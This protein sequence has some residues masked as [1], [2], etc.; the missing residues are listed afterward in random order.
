MNVTR[1]RLGLVGLAI[2]VAC[3]A[4]DSG[5]SPSAP[6]AAP[7]TSAIAAT[8]LSS[9]ASAYPTAAG[10]DLGAGLG[11]DAARPAMTDVRGV[12]GRIDAASMGFAL[13]L[14]SGAARVRAADRTEIIILGTRAPVPF[15]ALTKGMRVGV[16]GVKESGILHA[17]RIV[18]LPD[19]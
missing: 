9:G 3:G 16:R 4:C 17:R 2:V 18:I 14:P 8:P 6:S 11:G 7:S 15:S 13:Q 12:I 1:I 10:A 5:A 19:R